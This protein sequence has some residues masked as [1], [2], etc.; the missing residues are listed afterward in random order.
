MGDRTG[1]RIGGGTQFGGGAWSRA[2]PGQLQARARAC[3]PPRATEDALTR[4]QTALERSEQQRRDAQE[5]HAL[6]RDKAERLER[7][8]RFLNERYDLKAMCLRF[9]PPP[10]DTA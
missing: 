9:M 10:E 4:L 7:T 6:A 8:L 3:L 5:Q 2:R 1:E